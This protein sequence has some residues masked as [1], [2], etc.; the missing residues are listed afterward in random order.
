MEPNS[1]D[2][3][4][5]FWAGVTLIRTMYVPFPFPNTS[6]WNIPV[7]FVASYRREWVWTPTGISIKNKWGWFFQK[8]DYC[9]VSARRSLI[10]LS[11]YFLVWSYKFSE[12]CIDV[13]LFNLN[14][15]SILVESHLCV[16]S[17]N[18]AEGR[19]KPNRGWPSCNV[20]RG[21]GLLQRALGWAENSAERKLLV[22]DSTD[23]D[24]WGL[25]NV[26]VRQLKAPLQDASFISENS[27]LL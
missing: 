9:T 8:K 25:Q 1:S 26:L 6:I 2:Q 14:I 13:E 22:K 24:V 27:P 20:R 4:L 11:P 10:P 18:C 7:R 23:P 5:S 21:S 15:L 16:K 19:A 17:W 3:W 12:Q